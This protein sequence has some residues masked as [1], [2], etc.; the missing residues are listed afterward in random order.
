MVTAT[1]DLEEIRSYRYSPSHGLQRHLAPQYPRIQCNFSLSSPGDLLDLDLAPT[2]TCEL[3]LHSPWEEIALGPAV[4]LWDYIRRS[5]T[6]GVLLPLSGGLDSCSVATIVFSMC[7][8]VFKAIKGGNTTVLK[9]CRR[10]AGPYHSSDWIPESPQEICNGLFHTVYLGME[11]QSSHETRSRAIELS[12]AIGSYHLD[13]NIDPV[14]KALKGC[15]TTATGFEPKFK[16]EGGTLTENLALQNIQARG[17]MVLS[18]EYAQLL[19]LIRKRPG[20]G[21]L[22]VLSA[23]NL[24]EQLRGYLT[25]YDCSSAD[26]NLIGSISKVDL[27]QF[28][29]WA[30]TAF[31]LPC[32]ED[33]INATPTA[34]LEPI[35]EDYVQS[36]EADMGFTYQELSTLGRLRKQYRVGPYGMFER[37]LH[38]WKD[39]YTPREIAKKVKDFHHFYAINRHKQTVS[40]PSYHCETYSC[41]SHR[42]DLRP[43]LLPPFYSS[44]SFKCIDALLEKVEKR[45]EKM[46]KQGSQG[47]SEESSKVD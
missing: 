19:P 2:P 40:T 24:E 4:W 41:D 34:E 38:D 8:E 23:G 11:T 43:H 42:Y 9:D 21:G 47:T 20:G 7:R 14:F 37:L 39:T 32:L 36:D 1:V 33:F 3:R 29:K 10:I 28:L 17:R 27:K 30:Q 31:E 5:G 16:G 45:V 6:A 44:W 12:E 13:T 25:K 46:E 15:L 35:T 26:I 18:Y 22:L